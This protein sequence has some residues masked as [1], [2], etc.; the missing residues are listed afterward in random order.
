MVAEGQKNVS[1]PELSKLQ[2]SACLT[3]TGAMKLTPMAAVE[4]LLGLPSFH[5]TTEAEAQ[6]GVYRLWCTQQWI[7]KS[8]NFGHT[9]KP[10]DMKHEPIL[11]MG[12]DRM[13]L[14]YAYHKLFMVN[15][16]DKCEWQNRFNPDQNGAWAGTEMSP[17]P[18]EA[19]VLGCTDGAQE[20]RTAGLIPWYSRLKYMPLRLIY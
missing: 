6:A 2:K 17:R 1:R 18:I 14:R 5:M 10:Q 12:S 3:A 19:L 13:F 20:G 15:C 9:K 8:T 4:V 11:Q 16:P 7:P